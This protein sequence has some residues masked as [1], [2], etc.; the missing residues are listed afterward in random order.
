MVYGSGE[1]S[2]R[3]TGFKA[4]HP[5]VFP[6]ITFSCLPVEVKRMQLPALLKTLILVDA[7]TKEHSTLISY[8]RGFHHSA[9]FMDSGMVE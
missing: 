3:A 5:I 8:R 9:R 6:A 2:Y 1:C 4:V 7:Q